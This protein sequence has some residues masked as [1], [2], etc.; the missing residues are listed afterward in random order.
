MSSYE[1][2]DQPF[3]EAMQIAFI[4]DMNGLETIN[5]IFSMAFSSNA[6]TVYGYSIN[7][8]DYDQLMA[9]TED[10]SFW[11]IKFGYTREEENAPLKII[12]Y[13]TTTEGEILTPYYL[14]TG[15]YYNPKYMGCEIPN[16]IISHHK[17]CEWLDR[18]TVQAEQETIAKNVFTTH[19]DELLRGYTFNASDFTLPKDELGDI[20][21]FFISFVIHNEIPV[22]V[23]D[24]R[25][26]L[27]ICARSADEL[28]Y[29]HFFDM[30]SP[31]P[32]HC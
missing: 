28:K 1:E 2:I 25:F 16:S 11:K 23:S 31:C 18:Y 7:A 9:D 13:G 10:V 6:G 3:S 20:S 19:T 4:E 27:L 32:P 14:L 22:E 24:N 8:E 21:K 12:L 17:G 30:A 29:S 5:N 26:G 15:A